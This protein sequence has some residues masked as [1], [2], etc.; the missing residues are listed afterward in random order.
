MFSDVTPHD[1]GVETQKLEQTMNVKKKILINFSILSFTLNPKG[2]FFL[3]KNYRTAPV[4]YP[5]SGVA[6]ESMKG[7]R[8]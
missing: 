7:Q 2:L 5:A 6:F 4:Y 3:L 1:S 8:N